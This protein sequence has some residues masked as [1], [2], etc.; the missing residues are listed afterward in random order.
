VYDIGSEVE[1]VKSSSAKT[2]LK[3]DGKNMGGE[4]KRL[5]NKPS[6]PQRID[7]FMPMDAKD[8]PNGSLSESKTER[9]SLHDGAFSSLH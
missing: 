6:K 3:S 2:T 7:Y 8:K 5:S 4:R 1:I 9:E